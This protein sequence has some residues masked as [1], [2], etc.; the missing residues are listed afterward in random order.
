M[1]IDIH[2]KKS[3]GD[4]NLDCQFTMPDKGVTVLFGP[5]GSGKTTLLNCLAGLET[6][7]HAYFK[8]GDRTV[9][10]SSIKLNSSSH[11]RRIGYVFQDSR[12]FPHMNILKNLKYGYERARAQHQSMKMEEVIERFS[13]A[14]LL[15]RYPHQLSGGE[16]QR[17]ALA[18]ALLSSPQ[19]LILDEPISALDYTARQDLIPYLS[20]IHKELSIPVIYVS[21]ELK[22]VLQLGDYVLVINA[23]KLVD[24]GNLIDLC[25]SQPLLTQSEG[26]S[27]ILNGVVSALDI[28]HYISTVQCQGNSIHLSGTLLELNQEVRILVHARDVSLSLQRAQD[29]S[30]LNIL[31]VV[32]DKIN[33]A[34]DGKQLVECL[35]G[36]TRMLA[37]LSLRSV[38]KLALTPGKKVFAQFKATAMDR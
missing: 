27:F 22:E 3:F 8:M 33:R 1:A 17:V 37:M 34:S 25:I 19:M 18:R 16:K 32:V 11:T 21:H 36:D 30:I 4:F 29:S 24:A 35:L 9:D 28:S 2:Y 5:S 14:K 38:E 13:L 12:L 15:D 7:D 6:A 26:T 20:Y 31:P 10:D 23:G